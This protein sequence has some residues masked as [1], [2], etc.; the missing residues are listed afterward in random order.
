MKKALV[1]M[2]ATLLLVS[3]MT[4]IAYADT[5]SQPASGGSYIRGDADGDGH[6]TVLDATKVQRVL[7][8]LDADDDGMIAQR[9][10]VTGDTLNIMDA[11]AIQRVLADFENTYG[12]GTVVDH[13]SD[14]TDATTAP[15]TPSPTRDPDELPFVPVS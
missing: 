1:I 2:L 13:S 9:S 7:A 12:I 4:V 14:P 15:T 3:A 8:D 11:T 6:I 10:A 5:P